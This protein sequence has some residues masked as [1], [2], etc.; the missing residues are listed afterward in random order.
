[1]NYLGNNQHGMIFI[2][3]TEAEEDAMDGRGCD[4]WKRVR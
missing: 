4:G 2:P 3:G 1:M